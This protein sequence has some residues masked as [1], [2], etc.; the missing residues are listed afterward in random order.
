MKDN[1][2]HASL[3]IGKSFGKSGE[4]P[5]LGL[6]LSY[7]QYGAEKNVLIPFG[8]LEDF[9][10]DTSEKHLLDPETKSLEMAAL[11]DMLEQKR[12]NSTAF[13]HPALKIS[14][15]RKQRLED[16]EIIH[17]QK[18]F[19]LLIRRSFLF[20]FGYADCLMSEPHDLR[21]CIDDTY[22]AVVKM[23][24]SVRGALDDQI[25]EQ[26][27]E[28][29]DTFHAKVSEACIMVQGSGTGMM[30][31]S[32]SCADVNDLTSFFHSYSSY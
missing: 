24:T 2:Y 29:N 12:E 27:S 26:L 25:I 28:I 10:D 22:Y 30:Y 3:I 11:Q 6:V 32:G 23:E 19:Q 4:V 1:H 20:S 17:F 13:F 9:F 31:G 21:H 8:K 7:Y 14:E 18:L 16:L 15:D 5:F